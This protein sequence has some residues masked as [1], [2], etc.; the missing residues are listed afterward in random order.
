MIETWKTTFQFYH[1]K[2]SVKWLVVFVKPAMYCLRQQIWF[3]SCWKLREK[4]KSGA[5]D[6]IV[7]SETSHLVF[8]KISRTAGQPDSDYTYYKEGSLE[9]QAQYRWVDPESCSEDGSGDDV[10][11]FTLSS[12][13]LLAQDVCTTRFDNT[14][15]VIICKMTS[16]TP[17]NT[18]SQASQPW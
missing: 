9:Q 11:F 5:N 13:G 16:T 17:W 14:C 8:R 12:I 18:F 15:T 10:T 3:H 7:H 4:V 6:G 2:R 1:W